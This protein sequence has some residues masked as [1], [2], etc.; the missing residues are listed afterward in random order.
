MGRCRGAGCRGDAARS[1]VTGE[2]E[3]NP[4]RGNAAG[5][6][7]A[8]EG[9]TARVPQISAMLQG[10]ARLTPLGF[11]AYSSPGA[12]NLSHGAVAG[13]ARGHRRGR[14]VTLLHHRTLRS[15]EGSGAHGPAFCFFVVD[16][17]GGD[18]PGGG[19]PM[20]EGPTGQTGRAE[21]HP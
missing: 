9:R 4:V 3:A 17:G 7:V 18:R 6:R 1:R 8:G 15:H 12:P 20:G 13:S 11:R 2:E 5:S 19:K 21:I 10:A 14:A 16:V